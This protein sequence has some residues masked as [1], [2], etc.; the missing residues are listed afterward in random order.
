MR[1]GRSS[2]QQYSPTRRTQDTETFPPFSS[3]EN[4]L[5]IS[6][7]EPERA[8]SRDEH[9]EHVDARSDE[10]LEHVAIRSDTAKSDFNA[11]RGKVRNW[12]E[13]AGVYM[14]DAA[15]R[16]LDVSDY[17]NPK[18]RRYP[19]IPGEELKNQHIHRT[20]TNYEEKR[21]AASECASSIA[22]A[23]EPGSPSCE[24]KVGTELDA[25][26]SEVVGKARPRRRSTLEVPPIAY[27]SPKSAQRE[28]SD[29]MSR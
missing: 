18:A 15:H 19:W 2:T 20:S 22:S 11:G 24:V 9:L 6:I 8:C 10:H 26:D 23:R 3:D 5:H 27:H 17:D 4:A 16:E 25:E 29:E 1:R 12:F 28:G 21:R 14:S 13:K 7:T